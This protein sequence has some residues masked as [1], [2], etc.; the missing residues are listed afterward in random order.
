MV[1]LGKTMLNIVFLACGGEDGFKGKF[2]AFPV[3][4]LNAV[5]CED[6]VDFIRK[7]FDVLFQELGGLYLPGRGHQF[8][9]GT[10]FDVRSI[11]MT[12]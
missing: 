1:D 7:R 2:V 6:G 12:I 5:I 10:G 9:K 4:E 8:N 11:A 3:R